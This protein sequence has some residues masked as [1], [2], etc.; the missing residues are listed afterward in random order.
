MAI[1]LAAV[2]TDV[3][4]RFRDTTSGFLTSTYDEIDRWSN[5][6]Q[7]ELAR[8]TKFL[9]QTRGFY[10]S[11]GVP[12]IV[13]PADFISLLERPTYKDAYRLAVES[14]ARWRALPERVALTQ[15]SA[16]PWSCTLDYERVGGSTGW[17]LWLYPVPNAAS[18]NTTM[19]DPGGISATD[20]SVI[21]TSASSFP[22][23]GR[24]V[25]ESEE[26]YYST[27][28]G[29]TLSG[30]IRGFGGTV[31]AIHADATATY[32][33]EVQILY[34][35]LPATATTSVD[36]ELQDDDA[37]ALIQGVLAIAYDANDQKDLGGRAWAKHRELRAKM[38]NKYSNSWEGEDQEIGSHPDVSWTWSGP[39]EDAL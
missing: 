26:I 24:I 39:M 37:E 19:N 13:L 23:S 10:L 25:I 16:S 33:A 17:K 36:F 20:T 6:I 30:L 29:N 3:A 28:S 8:E 1:T 12:Y 7:A 38:K 34:A 5:R 21:L 15:Q 14:A 35:R 32:L 31:A 9:R 4:F 27:K 2:R 22:S 11:S 18:I